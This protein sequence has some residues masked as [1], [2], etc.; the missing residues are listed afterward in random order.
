MQANQM[1]ALSL[2]Q[3]ADLISSVG[4]KRTVIAQGH[5]GTGKTSGIKAMLK[6]RHPDHVYVEFDC[7]NKDI[8]DLSVPKF[9]KAAEDMISDYVE[10]VP[11]AE[12]G[13]HLGQKVIINF[14]EFLKAPQPVQKG[15]RRIMLERMVNSIALPEGSII[16]GTSNLGSEGLGDI[17]PAHQR[18]A[19]ISV[20]TRK[21]TPEEYIEWGLNNGMNHT[22]LGWVNETRSVMQTFEEV[23][24]PDENPYIF[25]PK[26]QRK[27]FFTCRSGE[28]ASDILNARDGMDDVT[29]TS[30]L[31]GAIGDRGAMDLMAFVKLSDQLPTQDSIKADPRTAKVPDS[32]SAVCMV[33]F[34]ALGSIEADWLDKWMDYLVRLDK[35]AQGM[36]ANGVRSEK[37]AKRSMVMKNAKFTKW[38]A[39][40]NYMF[41][42]DKK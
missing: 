36:F 33:V 20:T 8:Q 18:N 37:Y 42:A 1:Y 40:N 21:P 4:H 25:H 17:L 38:A 22:M 11:N 39:D 7:T 3:T 30:A 9:M 41:A 35:E 6:E 28:I 31:M 14:D 23:K 24:D 32:A 13:A 16:Y 10:F 5:M 34:R 15:V 12:L 2:E 27:A 19:I 26:Q 29:L